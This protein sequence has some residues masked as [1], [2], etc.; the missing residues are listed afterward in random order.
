M[1]KVTLWTTSCVGT[2]KGR[3]DINKLKHILDAKKVEYEEVD[4][5]QYHYRRQEMLAGSDGIDTLPQLQVNGRFVGTAGEVQEFEDWGEL[6]DLLRG[7]TLEEVTAASE[8]A[9]AKQLRDYQLQQQE[10][11]GEA[12][13][14]GLVD[15]ADGGSSYASPASTPSALSP[16]KETPENAATGQRDGASP[17]P[18][19][20][21]LFPADEDLALE[22]LA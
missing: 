15:T 10:L 11:N 9:A 3:T 22:Q 18:K 8:A 20:G 6:N 16:Y 21:A 2:L 7:V 14:D 4:L 19:S 17:N 13:A 1:V 5:A 12:A